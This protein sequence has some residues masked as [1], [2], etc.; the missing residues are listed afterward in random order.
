MSLSFSDS[1]AL[2]SFAPVRLLVALV[3][4]SVIVTGA[5]V[6]AV[7]QPSAAAA[8]SWKTEAK[9]VK[10]SQWPARITTLKAKPGKKPGTVTFTWKTSSQT[11]SYFQLELASTSF[12]PNV[13]TLPKKGR[14]YKLVKIARS[15]R[16][17]T[18]SAKLAA[19]VGAPLGSGNHIYYRFSAVNSAGKK[20][21][22]RVYPGLHTV[23]VAP[24]TAK[25]GTQLIVASYNIASV[26]ARSKNKA[27]GKWTT[28]RSKLAATIIAS[29][30]GIIALQEL[31]PGNI[32]DGGA[33][34]ATGIPRQTDDLLS[35]V[36]GKAG[37]SS[38]ALVQTTPYVRAGTSH[39][40]QGTRIMYDTAKYRLLSHC[41][42][43]TDGSSFSSR[44]AFDLPTLG[45]DSAADRRSAAFALFQDIS[46]GKK[47][48][49][50]SVH[51]D[52]RAS[53]SKK[54]SAKYSALRVKQ[55]KY[56]MAK[57]DAL[58]EGGYPIIVAGDFNAWQNDQ[59]SGAAPH[60]AFVA[61]GYYDASATKN[62]VRPTWPTTSQWATKVSVPASGFGARLD[63]ILGKGIAG[64]VKYVNTMVPNDAKRASDHALIWASL[65]LA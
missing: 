19:R 44:C 63:Y 54:T 37:G 43:E 20:K 25:S 21:I 10:K 2:R 60:R 42:S 58:N 46:S 17:F 11:T 32:V 28:R 51:L 47:F 61:A 12:S 24:A 52:S 6:A 48:W 36:R 31:G 33:V 3:A 55:A 14:N 7:S 22:T 8:A 49:V 59:V 57:M 29:K 64:S 15:A 53:T 1:P 30:A 27:V 16:S 40:T 38:Y 65:R 4:V 18:V 62:R 41:P 50:V 45:S 39:G 23:S 34:K 13:K 5:G 35:T 9:K 56:V 26:K